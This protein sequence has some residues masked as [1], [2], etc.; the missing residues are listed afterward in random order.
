MERKH[1]LVFL[2]CSVKLVFKFNEIFIFGVTFFP[3]KFFELQS[4]PHEILLAVLI[5]IF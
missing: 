1:W 3:L 2:G 5:R 4:F